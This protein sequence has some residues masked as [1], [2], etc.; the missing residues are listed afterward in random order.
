MPGSFNYMLC[1]PARVFKNINLHA[2]YSDGERVEAS[3][4][5]E[6]QIHSG[7]VRNLMNDQ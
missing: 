3:W 1:T 2:P 4:L 6:M 7:A 5:L